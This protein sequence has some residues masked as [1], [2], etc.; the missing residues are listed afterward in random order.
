MKQ[1]CKCILFSDENNLI[2]NCQNSAGN[3]FDNIALVIMANKTLCVNDRKYYSQLFA[4]LCDY[5]R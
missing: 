2:W 5:A 4:K 1:N 3:K